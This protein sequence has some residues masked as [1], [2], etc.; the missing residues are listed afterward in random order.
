MVHENGWKRRAREKEQC[1]GRHVKNKELGRDTIEDARCDKRKKTT[2]E[3][4]KKMKKIKKIWVR[5]RR[6]TIN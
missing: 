6:K 3:G 2:C 5:R 1:E 4:K